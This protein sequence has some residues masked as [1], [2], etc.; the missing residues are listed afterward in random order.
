[1]KQLPNGIYIYGNSVVHKLDAT[2]KMILFII[3]IAAVIATDTLTGYFVLIVFTALISVI[4]KIGIKTALGNV[5]RLYWF[6]IVIFLMNLCFFKTENAWVSFWIF[7]PSYDGLMQ[8]IKVVARVIAFLIFS[9]IINASTPPVEVTSAIENLI[10]PLKF[11]KVPV[12][13]LALIL[14]VSIQFIPILFEEAEMVKKAQLARGAHVES[15]SLINKAK[16]VIPMVVPIFIAAFRRADELS[17]AMEARGY[18]VDV[19]FNKRKAVH[20]GANEIISF[21]ICCALLAVQIIIF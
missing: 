17:V 4:S 2:V 3:L 7:N 9:N 8:G 1:M 5:L 20:I 21:L 16:S 6:F 13:Q 18:R 14:S 15:K 19:K 10:F 11:F 12:S